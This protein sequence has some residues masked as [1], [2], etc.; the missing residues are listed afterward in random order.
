METH[1]ILPKAKDLFPEYKNLTIYSWNKIDL[2]A[3]QHYLAHLLLWKA[4]GG[5]QAKAL[6]RM[7]CGKTENRNRISSKQYERLK[8]EEHEY[9]IKSNSGEN[10]WSHRE[11]RIHN[12]KINHPKGF[13]GK[14]HTE[15]T[16]KKMTLAQTG[17]KNHF[18]GKSHSDEV[19]RIISNKNKNRMWITNGKDN[20]MIRKSDIIPEGF[21]RGRVKP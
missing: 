16:R 8:L 4:F 21:Y 19:K 12:A 1:H 17:D 11:G 7:L 3:R 13:L 18:K 15:E 9:N 10:H 2:T 6:F 14:K 20:I 5:S